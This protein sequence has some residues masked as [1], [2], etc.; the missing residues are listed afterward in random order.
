VVG[1][2]VIQGS[3]HL[4]FPSK[5]K[6]VVGHTP[7][8]KPIWKRNITDIR[9]EGNPLLARTYALFVS[10]GGEGPL[11]SVAGKGKRPR[12]IRASD[13]QTWVAPYGGHNHNWRHIRSDDLHGVILASMPA[14]KTVAEAERNIGLAAEKVAAEV[15]HKDSATTLKHYLDPRRL[16]AYKA[17]L[18][19][20]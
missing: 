8:K 12:V 3:I 15:G 18:P 11:F 16:D 10:Q 5:S 9:I 14:P 4:R 19:E 1:L 13:T 20:K 7:D 2:D 17:N 6:R